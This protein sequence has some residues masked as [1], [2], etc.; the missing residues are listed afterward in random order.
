[1]TPAVGDIWYRAVWG[2]IDGHVHYE[3]WHVHV[4]TPKGIWVGRYHQDLAFETIS[5]K[6]NG[7]QW[8]TF[9]TRRISSTKEEA[10]ARLI[11]RTASWVKKERQ[12][13]EQAEARYKML[14]G[15][16]CPPEAPRLRTFPGYFPSEY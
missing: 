12:R 13:L 4:V 6:E 7:R 9:T 2:K 14:T 15:A 16:E 11:A 1:M 3:K 10:L 8:Y 5:H